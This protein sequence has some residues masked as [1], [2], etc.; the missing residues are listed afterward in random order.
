VRLLKLLPKL[1]AEFDE[2]LDW[3]SAPAGGLCASDAPAVA[4]EAP[5]A[6]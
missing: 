5:A 3:Q 6:G 4:A 2:A 1:L